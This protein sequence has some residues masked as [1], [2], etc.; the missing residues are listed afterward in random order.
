MVLPTKKVAHVK[1]C[2][3]NICRML[4]CLEV[5]SNIKQSK[6]TRRIFLLKKRVI[7][8]L[9]HEGFMSGLWQ[10]QYVTDNEQV[11]WVS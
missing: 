11:S 4:V 9:H 3:I 8:L 6:K 1:A 7:F 5:Q 10:A 2:G